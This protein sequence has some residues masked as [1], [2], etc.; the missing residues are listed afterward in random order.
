[1][2]T[3]YLFENAIFHKLNI[4]RLLNKL[5]N[6]LKKNTF[7]QNYINVQIQDKKKRQVKTKVCTLN[8]FWGDLFI[9]LM[10]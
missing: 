4:L 1:M 10:H 9:Y 7:T 6:S 3:H 8:D 5:S 2:G